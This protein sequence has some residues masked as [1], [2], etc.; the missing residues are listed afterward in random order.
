MDFDENTFCSNQGERRVLAASCSPAN[1]GGPNCCCRIRLKPLAL[2][3]DLAA[4]VAQEF[5][6]F[7]SPA[8]RSRTLLLSDFLFFF[9]VANHPIMQNEA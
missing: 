3:R 9:P 7:W 8:P 2:Y 1:E 6:S 4:V 5:N